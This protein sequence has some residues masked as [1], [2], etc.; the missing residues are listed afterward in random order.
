MATKTILEVSSFNK[1]HT[2]WILI[3]YWYCLFFFNW[4][5]FWQVAWTWNEWTRPPPVYLRMATTT[6]E[7]HP[8]FYIQASDRRTSSRDRQNRIEP[9]RSRWSATSLAWKLS[10][11]GLESVT[12]TYC[13]V[14]SSQGKHRREQLHPIFGAIHWSSFCL[15]WHQNVG[16]GIPVGRKDVWRFRRLKKSCNICFYCLIIPFNSS[17][18]ISS[19]DWFW[20]VATSQEVILRRKKFADVAGALKHGKHVQRRFK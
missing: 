12:A 2:I 4:P 9:D 6:Y 7:Q 19:Q 18:P 5:K 15:R 17:N 13:H 8:L 1:N 14:S 10:A 16:P 11:Q 3:R 20:H